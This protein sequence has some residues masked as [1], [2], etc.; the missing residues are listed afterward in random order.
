MGAYSYLGSIHHSPNEG[1]N[2]NKDSCRLVKPSF[3]GNLFLLDSLLILTM[4]S[5]A[6]R[7]ILIAVFI[8]GGFAALFAQLGTYVVV[9]FFATAI[10]LLLGHFRHGPML[11]ILMSLRKG[12]IAQAEQLLASIKRPN[13]LSKRYQAYYYF[14]NSLVATHRQDSNTAVDYANLALELNQLHD[15]EKAILVY[16]LARMAYQNQDFGVAK[17]HLITLQGLAVEDLHLKKRVGELEVALQ[18]K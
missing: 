5:P 17:Q 10:I 18:G 11:A 6:L 12:N 15:K 13:W 1:L 16:N 3:S 9:A 14:S 8:V 2:S 4:F 7:L